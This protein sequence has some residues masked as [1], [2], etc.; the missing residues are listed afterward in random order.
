MGALF[1]GGTSVRRLIRTTVFEVR[2]R[3]AAYG[4]QILLAIIGAAL[5]WSIAG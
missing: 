2:K 4:S 5:D 3:L 1:S